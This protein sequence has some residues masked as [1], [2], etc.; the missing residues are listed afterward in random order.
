VGIA[1]LALAAG[2]AENVVIYRALNGRS[3]DR[4]GTSPRQ[5]GR[6][7]DGPTAWR[8]PFGLIVAA[9]HIAMRTRRYMLEYGA[10]SR[11][12]GEVAVAFRKHASVNPNAYFHGRP[13]TLE[14]HQASPVIVDPL[15]LL[16]ITS[17]YDAAA[18]VIVTTTDRA[19]HLKQP[20]AYVLGWGQ[21]TGSK[22]DP[23]TASNRESLTAIEEVTYSSQQAYQMA[24]VSPGDIQVLQV[25]DHFTSMVIMAL[26]DLG[27][28]KKGE[29]FEFVQDGGI[30]IG[31]KLP[32]NTHGGNLGEGYIHFMNHIGQE[33]PEASSA[34]FP[35]NPL[36][37]A[38]KE[39][40]TVHVGGVGVSAVAGGANTGFPVEG[41]HLQAGVVGE[42][43]Y[44]A[45]P[46]VGGGL[47]QGVLSERISG[48]VHF[49][50]D[51]EV[52]EGC[53]LVWNI[54]Q[55]L[56]ILPQFTRVARCDE[57]GR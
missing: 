30:Q 35:G 12:F 4:Y 50:G 10:E 2:L 6:W 49:L 56:A 33:A 25:Y 45:Q 14:D 51:A 11:H 40:D 29:G 3:Q 44:S 19:R 38:Q 47:Q 8:A 55:Q 46:G 1:T 43:E 13:I 24:G 16:D 20:P 18:A 15:R 17:E 5:V 54:A 26:E 39:A 52:G 27:F 57:E 7:V 53:Q 28:C 31:G 23:M 34:P 36:Q 32:V 9:H 22:S 48:F 42:G 21:A 37:V 41:V